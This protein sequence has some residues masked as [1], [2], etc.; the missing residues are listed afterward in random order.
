MKLRVFVLV[1]LLAAIRPLPASAATAWYDGLYAQSSIT[2]CVSIIQ[3][4]PYNEIGAT[5]YVGFLADPNA[6]IPSPNTVYYVHVLVWGMG[7]S[8]SGQRFYLDVQLPPNTSL[9]VD[10]TNKVRC[11]ADGAALSPA[12]DCPQSL[13]GSSYNPGAYAIYSTD[14]AHANLWPL[15]Q[16]HWWEFQIPVRTTTVLTNATLQANVWVLDGNSS[17]WL[18]PQEGV[19][20]FS[21][22]PAT[23]SVSYVTPSTT[24]IQPTTAH[25]EAV[26]MAASA[27]T[28]WFD[29]GT[30]TAYGLIHESIAITGAGNWR[31]WDDW[32]PPA[33]APNTTYHWRFYFVPSVGS[34]VYGTDQTFTTSA[35]GLVPVGTGTAASCTESAFNA[36]LT[37]AKQIVFNCGPAPVTITLNATHSITSNLIINGGNKVTLARVNDGNGRHFTVQNGFRLTL[38]Q[39]ELSNAVGTGCGGAVQVVAG[40]LLT[41]DQAR[42]T[43]NRATLQGGAVCNS[44]TTD[45]TSTLFSDN[46]AGSHGGAIGNYGTLTMTGS[47]FSGNQSTGNGGAIDSTGTLTITGTTFATNHAG[48]R[49]GGINTYVG[50]LTV[51][52]SYFSG[53][54]AGMYGAGLSS[55]ASTTSVNSSTFTGNVSSGPG[56]AIE[57]GGAGSFNLYSSTITGNQATTSGGGLY[58]DPST[59]GAMYLVNSTF[60]DNVAG[61]TGGNVYNGFTSTYNSLITVKTTIVSAGSPNNCSGTVASAGYNLESTN[62]CGLVGAGDKVSVNPRL[63][64]LQDNGGPTLTRALLFGSPAIDGGNNPSCT[65]SDQRGVSR[66]QDGNHDGTGICDIGAVEMLPVYGTA[67]SFTGGGHADYA[68]FDPKAGQWA[69]QGQSASSWGIAGDVPV[70]ADY[71]GD[72]FTDIAVW[73]PANG[74]WYVK[75]GTSVQL[76]QAGDVPVPGDYLGMGK[77]Q[78]TVFRPSSGFWYINGGAT[79]AWG[80]PGDIPVPAD[81]DGDGITDIAVFRPST[82]MWYVRGGAT[83][84]WGQSGDIPVPADYNHDGKAEFAVY[85]PSAAGTPCFYL[86]GIGSYSYGVVGDVPVVQDMDGDGRLDMTV[87]RPSTGEWFLYSWTSSAWSSPTAGTAL[88]TPVMVSATTFWRYATGDVD[89]DRRRDVTI[90]RSSNGNWWVRKS[91]GGYK[92]IIWGVSGD[93]PMPADYDGDG[94]M[95]AAIYRPS[96]GDWWILTSSSGYVN[97]FSVNWGT[98]TDVPLTADLDGDR[99]ADVLIYRPSNGMWWALLSSTGY[100]TYRS[101]TWGVSTDVPIAGDFDG[102]GKADI[103]VYRPSNGTWWSLLSSVG[104][105]TYRS[106]TWGGPTAQAVAGDYDGDGVT[107]IAVFYPSTGVWY[108]LLSSTNFAN[109]N[110][111]NWG[112]STDTP[113]VGDFDGDGKADITVYRPSNGTWYMLASSSNYGFQY[114]SWGIAGDVPLPIR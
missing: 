85:R 97:S 87:Y 69:V 34:T 60:A 57:M 53:N 89:G 12:S 37:T 96:T 100:T 111:W 14:S 105:T 19:Y 63:G 32:G 42:F 44:G 93:V 68:S 104:Y 64:R 11:F 54:T 75:G 4:L 84:P 66:P 72:G 102:D 43:G 45:I 59:T 13:P 78:P 94:L 3:G 15:P 56:G 40:G 106:W 113:V 29:L 1:G 35:D 62:T 39:I 46:I 83:V 108:A 61:T 25:S 101:W 16:G 21:G 67:G 98:S 33:L 22:V 86:R 26:L 55:D 82:G 74:Y 8:C 31:V 7:N 10:A 38:K 48:W 103:T 6:S 65:A 73:R 88:Q 79:V 36:A 24:L 9:A 112:T 107:D 80:I 18:R 30:T 114:W 2:N 76:G 95:D 51:A 49:G 77:A 110:Y 52:S 90:Y 92:Q 41:L 27:G 28:G 81:Y 17:P 71:T 47:R 23:S 109:F 70:P 91:A 58:W 20:V 99:K 50:T 5:A